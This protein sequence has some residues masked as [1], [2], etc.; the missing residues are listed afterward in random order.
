MANSLGSW[1]KEYFGTSTSLFWGAGA[2]DCGTEAT[3]VG[4]VRLVPGP[5]QAQRDPAG[6]LGNLRIV[7]CLLECRS[8]EGFYQLGLQP[9][10]ELHFQIETETGASLAICNPVTFVAE[11]LRDLSISRILPVYPNRELAL[12]S[13]PGRGE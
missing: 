10:R 11:L 4:E 2:R 9:A 7:R 1:R 13:M 8:D 6:G 12:K 5:V 3:A